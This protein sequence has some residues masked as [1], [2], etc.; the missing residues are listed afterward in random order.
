MMWT[1]TRGLAALGAVLTV[2]APDVTALQRASVAAD[3]HSRSLTAP[4]CS[5]AV[6]SRRRLVLA[7]GQ[8]VHLATQSTA[9]QDRT[10][11]LAGMPSYT[12]PAG[13]TPGS[14]PQTRDSL[15]G[16]LVTVE[17]EIRGVPNPLPGRA[18]SFAKV[19]SAGRGAWHVV[20]SERLTTREGHEQATDSARLWYGRYDDRGWSDVASVGVVHGSYTAAEYTSDL[21]VDEARA[22]AFAYPL[23]ARV[24]SAAI[25]GVVLIRR[26][27]RGWSADTL[28]GTIEPRYTRLVPGPRPGEWTVLYVAQFF[29]NQQ[30]IN[31]SL[32]SAVWDGRWGIP[33]VVARAAERAVVNPRSFLLHAG[34][35]LTWFRRAERADSGTAPRI[36]WLMTARGSVRV[37]P[38]RGVAIIGSNEYTATAL[39]A[40]SVMWFARDGLAA[41][42]VRVAAFSGDTVADLGALRIRNETWLTA[43][44]LAGDGVALVA[45]ELGKHPGEPPAASIL[46]IVKPV[47][48]SG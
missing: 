41:D 30:L 43:L 48:P 25:S 1:N 3:G 29:D 14:A 21:V 35:L 47:C 15:V 24:G 12:W 42:R 2:A 45:S 8:V 40:D 32:H 27:E 34:L 46:T 17:G 31:A 7:D 33:M 20:L 38:R 26:V 13:A 39:G 36:E 5:L 11:L 44:N 22:L 9:R 37:P 16:V 4:G 6:V 28:R 18:L 23:S 10:I 19:A